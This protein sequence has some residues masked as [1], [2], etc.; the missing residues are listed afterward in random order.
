PSAPPSSSVASVP[1]WTSA[2]LTWSTVQLGWRCSRRATAPATWG[3][4][5]LVP[6]YEAQ[7]PGT[8]ERMSTPGAETPGLRRSEN[9]AGPTEEKSARTLFGGVPVVSTAATAIARRALAGD[10]TEPAPISS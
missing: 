7:P 9:A 8:D 1:V 10:E 6:S 2:D 5:M 3:E 4:A